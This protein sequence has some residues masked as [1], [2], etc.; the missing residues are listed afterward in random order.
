MA[1]VNLAN[2]HCLLR[3]LLVSLCSWESF[4]SKAATQGLVPTKPH[5]ERSYPGQIYENLTMTKA[6]YLLVCVLSFFFLLIFLY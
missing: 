3:Q 6:I 5:M 1:P 2:Q 4:S